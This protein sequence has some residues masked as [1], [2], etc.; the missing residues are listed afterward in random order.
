MT[1]IPSLKSAL[2]AAL[3]PL[4]ILLAVSCGGS[5]GKGDAAAAGGK[6]L[7]QPGPDA[8]TQALTAFFEA[9]EGDVIEFS[10]GFFEFQ[11]GLILSNTRGVTIRGAGINK[12]VLS[13]K[14][15]NNKE[16]IFAT[17]VEG[18]TI[19]DL[20]VEDMPGDGVKV[21]D[22][23]HVNLRRIK[24]RWTNADPEHANYDA[25]RESWAA[26]GAYAFY[27]VL[28]EDLILEDSI[29]IGSS[30]V[31]FYIG[32]S[33]DIIVRNNLAYHNVQGYE[34]ENTDDSEMHDN[35]ARNNSGGFLAVDLPGRTRYGDKSRFYRNKI[36]DNNIPNFAPKG[37]IAAA[38]PRGTGLIVL[39]TDQIEIFDNDIHDN[40]TLGLV[41][42]GYGLL[43]SSRDP[44]FDYY[45]EGIHV[46]NNRFANNGKSPQLPMLGLEDLPDPTANPSLLPLLIMLKNFGQTAHIAWDGYTDTLNPDCAYPAGVPMDERG[47]PQ[48]RAD[49]RAPDC[50]AN[51]NGTPLKYNAYKFD[52][53]GALR[54]PANGICIHD[55]AFEDTGLP[56]PRFINFNGT[57]PP[58]LGGSQDGLLA[59]RD[60]APFDCT[61]P[62]LPQTTVEPYQPG[63][64]SNIV[65][66]TAAEIERLCNAVVAGRIN[67]GALAVNCP[68][69]D[70]YGLFSD[71]QDPRS[72]PLEDGLPYD[73]S[74]PLFSDY[75]L[76]YRVIFLPPN[77]PARWRDHRNGPN[78][79][80]D[81]PSGT[82]IAKTFA[83]RDGDSEKVVETRLLIKRGTAEAPVWIGLPY[84]WE[85]GTDGRRV[86]K[87]VI[88]GATESAN[89]DYEDPDPRVMNASGE[90]LRYSGSTTAYQVPQAGQC[91]TCHA[92]EELEGGSAPIG[93]KP[94]GLNRDYDYGATLGVRNQLQHWC[95]TGRLVDCPDDFLSVERLP[96][97]NVPGSSGAPAGSGED[98][99]ARARAYLEANCAH[100]HTPKG[101]AKSTRLSLDQWI[102]S[103]GLVTPR[104]VDRDYGICKSPVA[105]GRGTGDRL[106]DIV[107]G[108]ADA[109]ILHFRVGNGDD[110][111]IRMPP[112]AKSVIHAEGHALIQQWINALPLATTQDN[113]CGGGFG[114]LLPLG[115][116]GL[117]ELLKPLT[118]R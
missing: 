52:A 4:L 99:E 10:E 58:P 39:A 106:Y 96:E 46:H 6:T 115:A 26:N 35:V 85:T 113:S 61:L 12:T 44:R 91:V 28:S 14:N 2:R 87:L 76:K 50:G 42:V 40:D 117:P 93:P 63:S 92:R 18:L 27:P 82:V 101:V 105:S 95:S 7:I 11:T 62:P 38:V 103:E 102:I 118:Q 77:Q 5:G 75:A 84:R 67:R 33:Q 88:A 36:H 70:Q 47:K 19:E 60:E 97:W 66:S 43:D 3:L 112:I 90:R 80:L 55:N 51:E 81:F 74:T 59:S 79:H 41:I 13:F 23:R 37:T 111:A 45:A 110:P 78:A 114:G 108:D 57:I 98:I 34:F 83:F 100:C 72:T 116:L 86:A 9:G 31:G 109:S 20:T 49:D 48:Y 32:Q 104:P 53:E 65:P 73:L 17:H 22:A 54:K 69:L 15:S 56:T 16:G 94:R 1:T 25:S 30:D 71:P 8:Q 29:S 107:P 89:W 64:G 68:R 24:V 21:S